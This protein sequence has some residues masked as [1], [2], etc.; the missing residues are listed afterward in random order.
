MD[1]R[2][3]DGINSPDDIKKLSYEDLEVLA[4]EIR[5][6]LISVVSKTGGHLAPNLGVVELTL[7]LHRSLASPQDKIV[8]DV[9]HQC[10]V[11]KLLTGRREQFPTLR[12]Q[13]GLAG[14]PKIAESKHD[15]FDTGHASTSISFALGLAEARDKEKK[16]E[17]VIVVIGDGSLTG[18]MAYEALN[19]AGHLGTRLIIILNDNEMSI[20]S[21][22]GAMSSYLNR[23]RL[24]PLYVRIREEIEE[25]IKKIPAIGERMVSVGESIKGAV[26][27]LVGEGF[28]F[29]ELGI[30]YI[31]PVDGHDIKMIEETMTL[32]K[33][34]KK[35]VIIH[36]LTR[37][38]RGYAPAEDYPEKFHGTAPFIIK[39]GKPK[40]KN[41]KP[42]YTEVFG[43]AAVDIAKKNKKIVALTAA[44]SSGTGL[45]KFKD[46][47]PNRFYDVGIAEQ[48]AVTFAAGLARG[49]YTPIVAIYSTFLERAYDQIIQDVCL[50]DL[51]V[52]F[53]L[54]R[55]G[56]VGEDGP[57]H[58]GAFDLSYLR[59]VPKM[60][61]MAPRNE[62]E[63][64]HMLF[65]AVNLDGPVAIRYP[66]GAG[67]GVKL[68]TDFKQ[69]PTGQAEVLA[70][71]SDVALVAV[72]R[73]VATATQVAHLLKRN[74]IS[75]TVVDARF[76]K[77]LDEALLAAISSS[78]KLVVTLE[79]NALKGGFGSAVLEFLCD[80]EILVPVMRAGLP[81]KFIA[82]GNTEEL[83]KECGL[84]AKSIAQAV[85]RRLAVDADTAVQDG[86]ISSWLQS[87]GMIS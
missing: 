55:A 69:I 57:T 10:Y 7:G 76:V 44:M 35:P 1:K 68:S 33:N 80:R 25:R 13:E 29:E 43:Q 12:Q 34:L 6:E 21:N 45:N 27:Y 50:Q 22:V 26:K 79:E 83:L 18:G 78:H 73:M 47:F 70:Q 9:G 31:G 15:V 23:I 63:L 49:G 28:I 48:H 2:I 54:D 14:F 30:S 77:P 53:A 41:P 66:R 51:H 20:A 87:G 74:Q 24:D 37:K 60:V 59:H 19:Q 86:N 4:A 17:H 32:A 52:I 58:H 46:A 71:G 56:I 64:R 62:E 38:G 11:H 84:D 8:W 72:G 61:V 40:A 36:T 82:H 81:D 16:D 39:T 65:T 75:A 42:S 85:E 3:L 5:E 67:L